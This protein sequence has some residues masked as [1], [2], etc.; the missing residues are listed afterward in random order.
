VVLLPA[1]GTDADG[2]CWY[3]RSWWSGWSLVARYPDGSARLRYDPD[4]V[5]GGPVL[6]DA[7]LPTCRSEPAQAPPDIE[8]AWRLFTSMRLVPTRMLVSPER[9]VSGLTTFLS[10]DLVPSHRGSLVSPVTGHRIE[11]QAAAG[12]VIID[13]GDGSAPSRHDPSDPALAAPRPEA[14]GRHT[15]E[16]SGVRDILVQVSWVVRWRVDAGPWAPI[17]TEPIV[18][19]SSV[20][21]DQIVGRLARSPWRNG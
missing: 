8:Y 17:P 7:V 9:P 14:A 3:R 11:V 6:A 20:A 19:S 4:G 10:I 5:P 15:Y 21:V 2:G 16:R 18:E 13:W 1:V 12:E